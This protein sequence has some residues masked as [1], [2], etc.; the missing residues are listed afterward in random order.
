MTGVL[1]LGS[2]G[3]AL[4]LWQARHV[5]D[6]LERIHPGLAVEIVEIRTEGDVARDRPLSRFGSRGVFV[7]EL[8]AA[9]LE[10]RIDLAVHSLKDVPTAVAAGLELCAILEREDPRDCLV[11]P[12]GRELGGLAAGTVVGTSSPR[13]V[14]Q[15]LAA[16][17]DL[18]TRDIR[19]NLDTRLR[20]LGAGEFGALL[21]AMA[22][23]NRLAPA[24]VRGRAL[25]PGQ[26]LPAPGQ[27]ALAVETRAGDRRV[28]ELVAALHH[29]STARAVTAERALLA[30]LGGGCQLPVGSLATVRAEGTI[31]LSAV[32][33][34]RHGRTV[35]RASGD[36]ADPV[37]VGGEVARELL[38]R[39]AKAL[40]EEPSALE[41]A[42]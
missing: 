3:S 40:L 7:K 32:V 24:G 4:A 42:P 33:A 30:A 38:A 16:R 34:G 37:A 5:R 1:R 41:A 18:T 15:L 14:A 27:G 12:D 11:T 39:G 17:P 26:M 31:A 9:L 13:R 21:V 25:E 6:R 23:L 22:G 35:L 19:G 36:G 29:E 2:R 20:K 10:E 8:E 28:A